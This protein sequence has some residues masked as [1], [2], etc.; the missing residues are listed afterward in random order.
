MQSMQQMAGCGVHLIRLHL[1]HHCLVLQGLQSLKT[2]SE[3]AVQA[4]ATRGDDGSL[5]AGGS[6]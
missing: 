5:Q 1:L 4:G 3:A 6:S 2:D